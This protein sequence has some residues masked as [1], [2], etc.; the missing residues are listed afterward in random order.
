MWE[1]VATVIYGNVIIIGDQETMIYNGAFAD[2]V[3]RVILAVSVTP[4]P[5]P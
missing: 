5:L 2:T 4:E 1:Q 3:Q